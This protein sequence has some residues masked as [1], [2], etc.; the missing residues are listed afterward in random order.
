VET[1]YIEGK[2]Y[3]VI[4]ANDPDGTHDWEREEMPA[5]FAG[6][7][8]KGKERWNYL[9]PDPADWPVRFAKLIEPQ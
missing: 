3:M 5:R 7:D 8:E 4:I 6:Y 1:P 2:F 9:D